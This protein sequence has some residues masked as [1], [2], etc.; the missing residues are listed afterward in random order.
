MISKENEN[1]MYAGLGVTDLEKQGWQVTAKG[2][3]IWW[4]YREEAALCPED[5]EKRNIRKDGDILNVYTGPLG[6]K[7]DMLF[8]LEYQWDMLP[9]KWQSQLEN[10][11]IDFANEEVLL[12]ALESLDEYLE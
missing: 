6:T 8:S 1:Q 4:L 5:L 10:G 2:N 7:G 3:G 9:E 11:G 12:S